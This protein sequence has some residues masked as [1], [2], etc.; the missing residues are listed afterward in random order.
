LRLPAALKIIK[1]GALATIQDAGRPGLRRFGIPPSGAMDQCAYCIGNLLVGNAD[2][3]AA[4]EV[5]LTGCVVEALMPITLAITG[6]DLSP[7]INDAAAPMWTALQLEPGDRLQFKKRT[8]GCRAY[9]AIRGGLHGAAFY[10]SKS[11]FAKGRMGQA[12]QKDE[13]LSLETPL[14]SLAA[15]RSLPL[16]LRPDYSPP[17][18]IRVVLGP[19]AECFTP[20]GIETFLN[21]EYRLSPQSDRQGLRTTGPA[22]EFATGPDIISDPTPLGAVQVPG[23]GQPI[24]LHCDGQSTGGYAKIAVVATAD[25]DR[26]A[27][28]FPGEPIRFERI[29]RDEA[30]ERNADQRRLIEQVRQALIA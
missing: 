9:V 8:T 17:H 22:I 6:G 20:R 30:I 27:Q 24:I 7:Q 23:D 26:L 19:Q 10:R 5:T 11:V 3:A 18:A 13:I 12:L 21:G 28:I 29:T 1:P 16:D 14:P 4:I 25:L 2:G 15:L